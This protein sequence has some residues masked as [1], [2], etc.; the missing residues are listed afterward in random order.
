[1][2]T[3]FRN[4][5]LFLVM[6]AYWWSPGIARAEE[7][8]QE[9]AI[10]GSTLLIYFEND[11]FYNE[12]RYYTN[13]VQARLISPDLRT[14]AEYGYLPGWL[15]CALGHVP[16]PGSR[17]AMQY[18]V[19]L[20]FGQHIYTPKDTQIGELQERD[21]PY[22]GYLYGLLALHA[23]REHRLDT[24]ELA[25][26]LIGPSALAEQSQNE[27][28]RI[29]SIDTAKGWEHQLKDE[30]ALMLTWSRVWRVNAGALPG[31][32]G[33]DILPRVEVSA[34]TPYTRA[35]LGGEV[36]FGWNMPADYGSATIRPGSGIMRP[37]E[38]DIPGSRAQ[39]R[40]DA[41][42]DRFSAYL[43]AGTS[44]HAVAYNSFLDGNLWKDSHSVDK[45]P[46]A[47]DLTWGIALN[48]YDY[49]IT[50]THVIRAKE[51]HGQDKGQNF[52]S[53]TLGYR[54]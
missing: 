48:I 35:G 9:R 52:G 24:L 45:F 37:M 13:A 27:V 31:G 34:G 49:Q 50:Y 28:H 12:D 32:W 17:G 16:F 25:A 54:F 2:K 11:L 6:G 19:S 44:G 41:F 51:F 4:I 42:T 36:R 30:P 21:R 20:G 26:G 53:I 8:R 15:N 33:W 39:A 5:V 1:M 18:N 7:D 29:R 47:G 23:K 43:F 38:E 10:S 14:L 46:L 3:C 40:S 22:A